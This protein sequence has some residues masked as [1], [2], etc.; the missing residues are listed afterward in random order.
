[1]CDV[2]GNKVLPS[3]SGRESRIE[4]TA[5]FS[6]VVLVFLQQQYKEVLIERGMAVNR[7]FIFS[8]QRRNNVN[9]FE[10]NYT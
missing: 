6:Q 7:N 2:V 4:V 8:N 5:Y 10:I 1:M 3:V 9:I